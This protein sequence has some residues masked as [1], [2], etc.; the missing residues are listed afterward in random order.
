MEE[1]VGEPHNP[2]RDLQALD[3]GEIAEVDLSWLVRRGEH[4]LRR[5]NMQ[6]FPVPHPPLEY[7]LQ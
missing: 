5:Q 3:L 7:A 4:H 1:Q 6:S 2:Q